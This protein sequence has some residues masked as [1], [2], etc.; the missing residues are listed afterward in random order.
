MARYLKLVLSPIFTPQFQKR[1]AKVQTI[2]ENYV[3]CEGLSNGLIC[4]A[5]WFAAFEQVYRHVKKT[6]L[7]EFIA[8]QV[9]NIFEMPVTYTFLNSDPAKLLS[10][11]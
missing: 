5:V 8:Q 9:A 1:L 6:I 11:E 2:I 4:C 10:K 7:Y 3:A